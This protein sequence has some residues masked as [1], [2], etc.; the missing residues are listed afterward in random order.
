MLDIHLN[1]R[2]INANDFFLKKQ[3]RSS[4]LCKTSHH[5]AKGFLVD[6]VFLVL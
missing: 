3:I 5:N 2:Y 6:W 4:C 1:Y